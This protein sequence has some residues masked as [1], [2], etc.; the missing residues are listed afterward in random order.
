VTWAQPVFQAWCRAVLTV[1]CPLT[2]SGRELLP[3]GPFILCSNHS[4][5]LDGTALMVASGLRFREFAMVAAQDYFF[6]RRRL[7]SAANLLFRLIPIDRRATRRQLEEHIAACRAFFA[8]G[9]RGLII[10]PEGTRTRTGRLQAFKRG[11]AVVAAALGVPLVPAAIEGTFKV[12]PKGHLLMRPG[13]L[14]VRFG[15]PIQPS[16]PAEGESPFATYRRIT[17]E[18]ERRIHELLESPGND[19]HSDAHEVVGMGRRTDGV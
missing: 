8:S 15:A 13:K 10:F 2:V 4:S 17:A 19:P 16:A 7:Q 6:D 11:T 5:H 18:L 1:Y 9:G 12:W 3:S 14:R